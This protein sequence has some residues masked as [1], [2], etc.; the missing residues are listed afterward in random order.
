MASS[1]DIASYVAMAFLFIVGLGIGASTTF[2]DFR[3]AFKNP[4][5]VAIGF[6]SQYLFMPVI[7]YLLTLIFGIRN[8]I[9]VGTVLVGCSPGGTTSNLFTYW[10]DG[11]VALSITMSFLS[12]VAAFGFMPFWIWVLVRKALN[13]TAEVEWSGL[14]ASLL[15]LVIPTLLGLTVRKINTERKIG[16]KF[17]W[18]WI[19]ILAS[20]FAIIFLILSLAATFIA[21]GNILKKSNIKVWVMCIILQ[22]IGCAFGYLVAKLFS[23]TLKDRRTICLE[24][25]IQNFTLTVAVIQLSFGQD[26]DVLQYALMFPICY[27]FLYLFWSPLIVLFFK[28]YLAT[29]DNDVVEEKEKLN[30]EKPNREK[31]ENEC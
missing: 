19:E 31:E 7:A 8:E 26:E 27:G 14:I 17:I 28:Y 22:P 25:G 4:K 30:E 21:Y 3:K 6:T 13:S 23:M 18:R 9:A 2:E 12:T 24:T 10:S 20:V 11:N 5:A 1:A 29:K 15:L 16:D